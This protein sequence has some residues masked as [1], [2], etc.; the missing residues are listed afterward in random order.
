M[1]K[2]PPPPLKVGEEITSSI[3]MNSMSSGPACR[4]DVLAIEFSLSP[5]SPFVA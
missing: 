4:T 2:V 1:R 3:G 5:H